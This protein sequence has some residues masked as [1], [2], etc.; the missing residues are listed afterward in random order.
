MMLE[1]WGIGE[2]VVVL[3]KNTPRPVGSVGYGTGGKK[4]VFLPAVDLKPATFSLWAQ[5]LLGITEGESRSSVRTL[6]CHTPCCGFPRGFA[7]LVPKT[8]S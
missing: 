6:S 8:I 4:I 5:F 2:L 3:K 1:N 7:A